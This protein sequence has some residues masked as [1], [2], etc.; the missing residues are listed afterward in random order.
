VNAPLPMLSM[1]DVIRLH[2]GRLGPAPLPCPHC[3]TDPQPATLT[4]GRFIVTCANEACPVDVQATGA[5]LKE[6]WDRWN[7][8]APQ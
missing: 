3:G 6:A 5:T 2:C 1:M 4:A 8:R 7:A